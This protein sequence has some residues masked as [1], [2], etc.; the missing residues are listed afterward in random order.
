MTRPQADDDLAELDRVRRVFAERDR[1]H[2][3]SGRG[4][5]GRAAR[6][7]AAERLEMTARILRHEFAAERHPR[8][9]DVGCG[10]GH[11]L[12]W[13]LAAGWPPE[14]LAGIDLVPDRVAQ[15][16]ISVPG[17][18][19]RLADGVDLPFEDASFDVVTCVLVLSSIRTGRMRRHLFAE[20]WRVARPAGM[21]VV[22]DFVVRKPGSPDVVAMPL[23]LLAREA[24]R[25]ATDS[26]RLSP[27]L[28]AVAAGDAIH[29]RLAEV[30]MRV[31]PRTHRLTYWRRDVNGSEKG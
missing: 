7:L 25:P 17:A 10:S 21:F 27:F 16:R 22:Y 14:S 29:P 20:M 28:Y 5:R 31:A 18:D 2:V 15:A 19:I 9:L 6:R 8:I 23:P 11:D 1:R 30:A 13:F 26:V 3:D 24:G 12:A 4:S